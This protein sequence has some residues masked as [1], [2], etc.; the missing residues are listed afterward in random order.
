VT[1][2]ETTKH[3]NVREQK[4]AARAAA[5]L[6]KI[7]ATRK[8]RE[9]RAT[10]KEFRLLERAIGSMKGVCDTFELAGSERIV[11][12]EAYDTLKHL[13]DLHLAPAKDE[14]P[15]LPFADVVAVNACKVPKEA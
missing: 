12:A 14:T 7:E 6:A 5:T 3:L 11:L 2:A 13:R 4:Q 8:A 15:E 10:S 9:A 1:K